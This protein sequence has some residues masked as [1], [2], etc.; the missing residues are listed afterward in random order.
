MK[1]IVVST[2]V[3]ASTFVACKTAEKTTTAAS[4]AP[5]PASTAKYTYAEDIKPIMDEYCG[6]CHNKNEKAGYNLLD[7]AFV[8]KAGA[9][10]YLLGSIKHERGYD[11]MPAGGPK[12]DDAIIA[13]IEAWVKGGMN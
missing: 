9:N 2:L 10:G 4:P 12:M 3:I 13:K 8:K 7:V 11:A 1:K 5:A 6:G